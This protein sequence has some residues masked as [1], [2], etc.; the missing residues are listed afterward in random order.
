MRWLN[1]ILESGTLTKEKGLAKSILY[2]SA[3]CAFMLLYSSCR[4]NQI[5]LL[6]NESINKKS[7]LSGKLKALETIKAKMK[8]GLSIYY[9]ENGNIKSIVHYKNDSL[10]GSAQFF[11]ENGTLLGKQFYENGALIGET[12]LFFPNGKIKNYVYYSPDEQQIMNKEYNEN[13]YLA[14]IALNSD[15]EKVQILKDS[16]QFIINDT[17]KSEIYIL[18]PPELTNFKIKTCFAKTARLDSFDSKVF[19]DS[20]KLP[21][22]SFRFYFKKVL[23][24]DKGK[25]FYHVIVKYKDPKNGNL[26]QDNV[27]TIYIN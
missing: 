12:L 20:I 16:D 8:N 26:T 6:H 1:G 11:N 4:N 18:R 3:I 22:D 15:L 17:F 2:K 14:R 10:N 25:Y 13:G 19:C 27:T 21:L 9:F 5:S 7:Y 23:N 24:F